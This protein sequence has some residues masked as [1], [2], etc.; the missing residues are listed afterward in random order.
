[1][2]GCGCQIVDWET[3]GI[4]SAI[5]PVDAVIV[6]FLMAWWL[7]RMLRNVWKQEK[8]KAFRWPWQPET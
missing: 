6:S 2:A 3:I 5:L 1:M 8:K 4:I 7:K